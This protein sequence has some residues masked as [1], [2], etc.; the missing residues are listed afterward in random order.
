M[1]MSRNLL[2]CRRMRKKLKD[3]DILNK[4]FTF[5]IFTYLFT[6]VFTDLYV[7]IDTDHGHIAHNPDLEFGE[8]RGASPPFY[9]FI[10]LFDCLIEV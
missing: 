4:R 3:T 8:V 10:Y 2:V 5:S 1:K 9:L 7:S 6:Y